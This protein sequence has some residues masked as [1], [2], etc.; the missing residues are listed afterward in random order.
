MNARYNPDGTITLYHGTT[1]VNGASILG[2]GFRA[3]DP[4]AVAAWVE[5]EFKLP[6]GSVLGH[7]A[8][9]FVRYRRD[10][11]HVHFTSR[12]DV[13]IQYTVPEQVQDALA[14]VWWLLN[15]RTK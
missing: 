6:A 12:W 9:A 2:Q 3:S 15:T 1:T 5:Q 13:A 4:V 8:Y 7:S 14:A 10:L 11:D